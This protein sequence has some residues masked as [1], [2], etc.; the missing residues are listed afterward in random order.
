MQELSPISV[1]GDNSNPYAGR[2]WRRTFPHGEFEA[3]Y[4]SHAK[5]PGEVERIN[6]W[7]Q[8]S[9]SDNRVTA[10]ALFGAS[11]PSDSP[12]VQTESN[13]ARSVRRARQKL[14]WAIKCIG[15]DRLLT[16]T[17]RDNVTDYAQAD[18]A[19]TR[20]INMCKREWP[21]AW[22]FTAVPEIQESR[23]ATTGF[24]VWHFHLALRGWWNIKKLR[25]F[26]YRALGCRVIWSADGS[27]VL[28]DQS[29]TPGSVNISDP[30]RG[31]RGRRVWAVASIA[32]YLAKYVGKSMASEDLGGKPSYR[33]TRGLHPV[34]ER[35][36]VKALTF[37]DV[38]VCFLDLV[39][40]SGVATPFLW[41]SKDRSC[42]WSAGQVSP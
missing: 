38:L 11:L 26:W 21:T 5:A 41:Q 40:P 2:V 36:L 6:T 9:G 19:L 34:V 37:A 30:K 28:A 7:L 1:I 16:L 8:T 15:A 14:R 24:R 12:K 20:F 17:F 32:S 18:A 29:V 22:Q 39:S 25:G 33:S 27:P 13:D 31:G 10:R 4:K 35:F 42:L 23:A 3:V